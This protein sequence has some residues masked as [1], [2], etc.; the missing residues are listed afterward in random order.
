M[1]KQKEW[2]LV[3]GREELQL[4]KLTLPYRSP[5]PPIVLYSGMHHC[6]IVMLWVN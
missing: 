1:F 4:W 5:S 3:G 6:F 2:E